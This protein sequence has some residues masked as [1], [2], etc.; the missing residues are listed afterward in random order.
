MRNDSRSW[1][2][3]VACAALVVWGSVDARGQYA[4]RGRVLADGLKEPHGVAVHPG[5][6]EIYV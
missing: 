1:C 5:T 2:I 3:P 6:G 4:L